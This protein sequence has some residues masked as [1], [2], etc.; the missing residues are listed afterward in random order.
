VVARHEFLIDLLAA[1]EPGALETGIRDHYM[2]T[3]RRMTA[4]MEVPGGIARRETIGN[5][6]HSPGEGA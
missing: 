5:H 6:N 4:A 1:G 3:A 2:E